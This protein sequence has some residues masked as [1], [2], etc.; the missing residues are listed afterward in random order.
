M[1]ISEEAPLK[2]K[3]STHRIFIFLSQHREWL[4]TLLGVLGLM[5]FVGFYDRAFPSAAI[6]LSLSRAEI[7]EQA[8][9]Y[10]AD[11]GYEMDDYKYAVTFS[12]GGWASY[13]LQ[14]TL[15]IPE[16]NRLIPETDLPVWYWR[17]RWFRPLQKEAFALYLDPNG[18]VV[19]L[20]HVVLEDAAG[21]SLSQEE[22]RVLAQ[23]YLEDDRGWDLTNWEAVSSS[24]EE[25]PGGRIDHQ[26]SWKKRSWDV[27]DSQLRLSVTIQGDEV[28]YYDYWLKV[29]E[30]F[31]RQ[32]A[33]KQSVAGFMSSVSYLGSMVLAACLFLLSLWRAHG[34][35]APSFARALWPGVAASAVVLAARLN[36]LPLAKA[37]YNTTQDYGLFWINQLVFVGAEALFYGSFILI[38]WFVGQWLSKRV[39]PR[40][41][42]ILERR[43]DRWRH[44]ARSGWRGLMLS[45]MSGGYLVLFYLVATEILGGWSPM[46]PA[47]TSAYAT[48]LPFLGALRSGLIPALNEELLWRLILISGLLW[49][50][51]TFTGL[52]KGVRVGLALLI[53]GALWGFAHSSYIRDPITF[54][55]IELTIAAILFDGLFFLKFDLVTTMVAH[56]AF[57]AGLGAIPLLRSGEPYFIA[58]GVVILLTMVAPMVPYAVMEIRRRLRGED[59]ETSEPTIT[60]A[61]TQD[62]EALEALPV[63]DVDWRALLADPDGVALCLRV[64]DRVIGAAAGRLVG[65]TE[66]TLSAVFVDPAWRRRYWGSDLL[67]ALRAEL[68][69]RGAEVIRCEVDVKNK[70][71]RRFLVSRL[72]HEVQIVFQWPPERQTLPSL[73]ELWE[74]ILPGGGSSGS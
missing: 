23:T 40:Q 13:Y 43:G 46:S 52:P 32:F 5:L 50:V 39:W 29:P 63:S 28:G 47:Y 20:S 69:D 54:R 33:E 34:Q 56:F 25:K 44:L 51:R 31:K 30:T 6:D 4:I 62:R 3:P 55:G 68:C 27:G 48:P 8:G 38:L 15:G 49:F 19:G 45:W 11:L 65:D 37:G 61:R 16:T 64:D 58:S 21:A 24:S 74:K 41:D 9:A 22:A 1:K 53:P 12:R 70:T 18:E 71:A 2:K 67:V 59:R 73:R 72:W 26:F 60:S 35:I 7:T 66:G 42:R 10:M 17:S 14:R 57:N 36:S